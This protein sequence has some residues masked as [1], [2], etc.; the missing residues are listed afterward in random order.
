MTTLTN[1]S[2]ANPAGIWR[3]YPY[4][5]DTAAGMAKYVA[6]T[7]YAFPGGYELYAVTDDGAVLCHN[8]CRTEFELIAK[9]DSADGWHVEAVTSTADDD[10][11]VYCDHCDK[12]I[13]IQCEDCFETYDTRAELYNH[14]CTA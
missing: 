2:N 8:C 5:M 9:S 1:Y 7:K 12:D 11:H 10:S 13:N 14:K 6:R 3:D 4:N